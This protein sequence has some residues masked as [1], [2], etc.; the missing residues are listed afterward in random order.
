MSEKLAYEAPY[1]FCEGIIEQYGKQYLRR[2]SKGDIENIY[3]VHQQRQGFSRMLGSLNCTHWP[4][5][6]CQC[7]ERQHLPSDHDGP[8]LI[9]EAVA[10]FDL[11]IWHAFFGM[12]DINNDIAVMHASPIFDNIIDGVS[13]DFSF[14]ADDVNYEYRYYLVDDIYSEWATLVLSFAF[15]DDDKCKYFK[16]K[17]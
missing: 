12:P 3:K 11:W 10:L 9:F 8:K 16:K 4:Y 17:T 1:Q 15:P 13:L 5:E 7:L 6:G 2:P 14:S